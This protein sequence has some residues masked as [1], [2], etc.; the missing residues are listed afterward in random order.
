MR[1]KTLLIPKDLAWVFWGISLWTTMDPWH[2]M[3]STKLIN[4]GLTKTKRK[5]KLV[6]S[7]Q[8]TITK[9]RSCPLLI[10]CDLLLMSKIGQDSSN[11][12]EEEGQISASFNLWL[13]QRYRHLNIATSLKYLKIIRIAWENDP[14]RWSYKNLAHWFLQGSGLKLLLRELLPR[15][16]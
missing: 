3:H 2:Q 10:R 4:K 11:W 1:L 7:L 14:R 12:V 6:L 16:T 8:C 15:V 13:N 5:K 9:C